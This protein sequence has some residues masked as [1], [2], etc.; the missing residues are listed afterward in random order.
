MKH[1]LAP[2]GA[3]RAEGPAAPPPQSPAAGQPFQP[4]GGPRP[5]GAIARQICITAGEKA[6]VRL[7]ARAARISAALAELRQEETVHDRLIDAKTQEL[8][9]CRAEIEG[10]EAQLAALKETRT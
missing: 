5:I 3:A 7:N 8:N 1:A 9:E 4:T 6:L 10:F 2:S